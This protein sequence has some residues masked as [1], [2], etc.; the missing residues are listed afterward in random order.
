MALR[1]SRSAM[2]SPLLR[3]SR[4]SPGRCTTGRT[5]HSRRPSWSCS[6]RCS[7]NSTWRSGRTPT[8]STCWLGIANG[9]SSFVLALT[10]A[11]ARR[12][13]PTRAVRTCGCSRSFTAIG[14]MPTALLAFVGTADGF[15][16]RSAVRDRVDRLLGRAHLLRLDADPRRAARPHRFGVGLRLCA[17]LSRRRAAARRQCGDV[18]EAGSCSGSPARSRRSGRRS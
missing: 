6:S 3:R 14:V 8:D 4:S 16:G 18:R 7:S 5:R 9:I 17:R 10:G 13:R 15:T 11:V 12:A 1:R 2:K